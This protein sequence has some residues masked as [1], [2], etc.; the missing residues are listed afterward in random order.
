MLRKW[1]WN[2]VRT[3]PGSMGNDAVKWI[4]LAILALIVA[5]FAKLFATLLPRQ[6]LTKDHILTFESFLAWFSGLISQDPLRAIAIAGAIFLTT[7]LLFALALLA[8]KFFTVAVNSYQR[9]KLVQLVGLSG[10]W[11]DARPPL[12]NQAWEK[13]REHISG[14]ENPIL[15]IL[16]ATGI[17][18][19]GKEGSPLWDCIGK[20]GGDIRIILMSPDSEFLTE[21]ANDVGMSEG[22]YREE[23]NSALAQIEKWQRS[24]RRVSHRTYDSPPNWKL[25]LTNKLAWVQYYRHRM[26][27]Q[28]TPVYQ[29]YATFGE[30]GLY[31]VFNDEFA[32][33]WR[34]CGPQSGNELAERKGRKVLRGQLKS[35]PFRDDN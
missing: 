11:P 30:T 27:V 20:Y 2:Q 3:V 13:L 34:L 22:A 23:I 5:R 8:Q 32:R 24:G 7:A 1:L 6:A 21:R 9:R 31:H 26:H 19:F 33:I 18:T 28:E 10:Y 17:D 12:G 35:R 25:I 29:F 14:A 4:V 15:N 16:G